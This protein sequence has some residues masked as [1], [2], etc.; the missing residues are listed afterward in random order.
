MSNGNCCE[1]G[2]HRK[3]FVCTDLVQLRFLSIMTMYRQYKYDGCVLLKADSS[4]RN[5]YIFYGAATK[6]D[7]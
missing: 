7:L 6:N 5:A 1:N 3:Y 2:D 4:L